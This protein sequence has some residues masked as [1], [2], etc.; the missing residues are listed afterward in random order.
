M[1]SEKI[2]EMR[3]RKLTMEIESARRRKELGI[4]RIDVLDDLVS[5]MLYSMKKALRKEYPNITEKE[6]REKMR[7]QME[8]YD[9]KKRKR[10][11]MHG[12]V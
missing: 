10:S 2:L 8:I 11:N 12:R 5:Q 6:I 1:D 3:V 7:R 4:H 9:K